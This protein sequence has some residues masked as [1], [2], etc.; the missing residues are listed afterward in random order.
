LTFHTY[1]GQDGHKHG[2]FDEVVDV[3]KLK[4]ATL[5]TFNQLIGARVA[6]EVCSKLASYKQV[7]K[8]WDGAG[9]VLEFMSNVFALDQN[10]TKSDAKVE[11]P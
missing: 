7:K 6:I 11:F 5:D 10:C 3:S 9:N 8:P 1:A 2:K 4:P